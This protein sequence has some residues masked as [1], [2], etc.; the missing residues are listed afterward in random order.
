[1]FALIVDDGNFL[2]V[3]SLVVASTGNAEMKWHNS[4]VNIPRGPL[5]SASNAVADPLSEAIS[6]LTNRGRGLL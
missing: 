2:L 1:M 5:W 4:I 6:N 3:C